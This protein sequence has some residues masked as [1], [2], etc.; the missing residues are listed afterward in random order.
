[1]T[2]DRTCIDCGQR[3]DRDFDGGFVDHDDGC[4]C[5]VC[6]FKREDT[7]AAA[8]EAKGENYDNLLTRAYRAR[9]E[10]VFSVEKAEQL[11]FEARDAKRLAATARAE[12]RYLLDAWAKAI[13]EYLEAKKRMSHAVPDTAAEED[14]Q[15]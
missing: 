1:M 9:D 14:D 7:K 8:A 12:T 3:E 6:W 15:R 2:D 10:Y 4:I 5:R 13:Q 11:L